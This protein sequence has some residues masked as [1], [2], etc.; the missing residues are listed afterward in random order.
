MQATQPQQLPQR[1][2]ATRANHNHLDDAQG[3]RNGFF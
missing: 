3:W 1:C 2:T